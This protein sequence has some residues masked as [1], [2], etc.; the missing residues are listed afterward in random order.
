MNS[1]ILSSKNDTNVHCHKIMYVSRNDS[2]VYRCFVDNEIGLLNADV[3]IEVSYPPDI[4]DQHINVTENNVLRTLQCLANGVPAKYTYGQWKHLSFCG[5]YI[6]Y[7]NSTIDGRVMSPQIANKMK[8]YQD[9]GIYICTASNGVVDRTGNSFQNGNILVIAKGPPVFVEKIEY[10]QYGNLGRIFN[11]KF[12]VYS[13]S[14]IEWYNIKSENK[15]TAASIQ[16]IHVNNTM[17]TEITIEAIEIVLSFNIS[18]NSSS[19]MYTVTLCNGYGNYSFEVEIKSVPVEEKITHG[20]KV[21]IIIIFV[22]LVMCV[23]V[24]VAAVFLRR[25][26][27]R[28][29][30]IVD[31]I[32]E[33]VEGQPLPVENIVYEAAIAFRPTPL[34]ASGEVI[35]YNNETYSQE[36]TMRPLTGQLNYSDM[37]FQPSTSQDTR[38]IGIENRTVYSDVINSER[39]SSAIAT[40]SISS[41]DEEDF[42]DIEGLENFI[43]RSE[44]I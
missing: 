27:N 43:D 34:Q 2:G 19:H 40:R 16:M 3:K 25:K 26:R 37:Y 9:N 42:V 31:N 33:S 4:P 38:I 20:T 18:Q 21:G 30:R 12:F 14:E 36:Q 1:L 44:D 28:K 17:I 23:P 7:L 8:R 5:E 10:D 15:E 24:F 35:E 32:P 39:G 13:K 6:R 11:L 29:R 41:S 22:I